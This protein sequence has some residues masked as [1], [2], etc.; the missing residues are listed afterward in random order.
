MTCRR[1]TAAV[2]A[3]SLVA[4]GADMAM[5]Q[6]AQPLKGSLLEDAAAEDAGATVPVRKPIR[7]ELAET[8]LEIAP[9]EQQAADSAA[10]VPLVPE[11]PRRRKAV[12]DPY[13]P[14]G[15]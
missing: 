6:S 5:A 9:L 10:I 1:I 8:N 12:E 3:T 2:L 15:I 7:A 13:A 4:G 11:P 14:T